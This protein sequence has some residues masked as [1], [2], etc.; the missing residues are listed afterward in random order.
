MTTFVRFHP[1]F[2][3]DRYAGSC[4]HRQQV[5]GSVTWPLDGDLFAGLH[6]H[7]RRLV[8]KAQASDIDVR[9]T[10]GP[11]SLDQFSTLYEQTMLRLEASSFYFFDA[12]YWRQLPRELGERIALFE[13]RRDR[14]LLGGVFCF[15][16]PPWFHYHLGATSD[17]ARE[18]VSVSCCSTRQHASLRRTA[19]HSFT[20]AQVSARA[21]ARCSSSSSGSRRRLSSSSGSARLCTTST[22]TS[23]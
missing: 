18:S 3:N 16:T 4:F 6:R 21:V 5:E 1:L 20:W 15:A 23:S 19:T 13:A 8:R 14:V 11:H 12:A 22:A 2:G 17:A 10:V 7:H 9:V